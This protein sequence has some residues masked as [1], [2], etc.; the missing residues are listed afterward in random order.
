MKSL[1]TDPIPVASNE[2]P[3]YNI[4]PNFISSFRAPK[5][6][7]I[8]P[9]SVILYLK[10]SRESVYSISNPH[11]KDLEDDGSGIDMDQIEP[12]PLVHGEEVKEG[13]LKQ[14]NC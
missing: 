6:L 7:C 11:S 5:P 10:M 3:V 9:L 12:I 4:P 8:T 2:Y 14:S 1:D 13:L